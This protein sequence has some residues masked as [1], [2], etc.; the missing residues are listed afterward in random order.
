MKTTAI[1]RTFNIDNAPVL[2]YQLLD[3]HQLAR[4]RALTAGIISFVEPLPN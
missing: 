4:P 3:D 1:R 2:F